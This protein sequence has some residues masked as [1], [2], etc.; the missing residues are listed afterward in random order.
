MRIKGWEKINGITY[1]GYCMI[2]PMHN[3]DETIYFAD[4]M[5]ITTNR[6]IVMELEMQ[7]PYNVISGGNPFLDKEHFMLHIRDMNNRIRITRIVEL[8]NIRSLS[9]FRQIFELCIEDYIKEVEKS[10]I[11]TATNV[12]TPISHSIVSNVTKRINGGIN[13]FDVDY[14]TSSLPTF[15]DFAK[16]WRSTPAGK[17]TQTLINK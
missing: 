16:M 9:S 13:Q 14:G 10:W 3:A 17:F 6:T 7:Q 1:K 5:D 11:G 2:N 4:I 12:A 15:D 8:I